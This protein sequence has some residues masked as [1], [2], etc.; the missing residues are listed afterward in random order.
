ME[1]SS[2][3]KDIIIEE[4]L[5]AKRHLLFIKPHI[6]IK[7]S[8]ELAR[9]YSRPAIKP[10]VFAPSSFALWVPRIGVVLVT[11]VLAVQLI[12]SKILPEGWIGVLMF[13]I[14]V[15]VFSGINFLFLHY[16][17]KH[18]Y[19]SISLC[20][21]ETGIHWGDTLYDWS[22][23]ESTIVVTV[24][25]GT[26][27]RHDALHIISKTQ[28]RIRLALDSIIGISTQ[29]SDIASAIEHFRQRYE[30]SEQGR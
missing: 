13:I 7:N 10:K 2:L 4:E 8:K 19:I 27:Y 16:Y 6:I 5:K 15:T 23:I 28:G 18:Q 14:L 12:W 20:V 25:L 22:D 1:Q 30:S 26:K 24:S 17:Y 11:F 3:Y 29:P 9:R 21:S